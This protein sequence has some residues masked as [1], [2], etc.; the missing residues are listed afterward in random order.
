LAK[1]FA[2]LDVLSEGRAIAA[3]EIG[4]SKDEYRASNIPF[5]NRGMMADEFVQAIKNLWTD[6]IVEDKGEFYN[7]PKSIIGPKPV[8]RPRIPFYLGRF[9][10][11]TLNRIAKCDAVKCMCRTIRTTRNCD[12]DYEVSRHKL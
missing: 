11:N 5:T 7:T 6:D 4:W 1:R 9:S 8:Q 12:N 10:P 2:T 3:F